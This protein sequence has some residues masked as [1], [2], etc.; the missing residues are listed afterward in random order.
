MFWASE[1][2]GGRRALR[3]PWRETSKG[4]SHREDR[5]LRRRQAMLDPISFLTPHK[6]TLAVLVRLCVQHDDADDSEIERQAWAYVHAVDGSL[7]PD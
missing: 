6:V 7:R 5:L 2:A 4:V 1:E 3:C